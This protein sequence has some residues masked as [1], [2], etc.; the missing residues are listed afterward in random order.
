MKGGIG[1]ASIELPNGLI[2][3]ALVAVNA[4]GDVIDPATGAV[5]AGISPD[6]VAVTQVAD[7]V[8]PPPS[9][10]LAFSVTYDPG[11]WSDGWILA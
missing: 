5:V 1:S 10:L 6:L 11:D 7:L 2:V 3:S 4:F 8:T 9:A